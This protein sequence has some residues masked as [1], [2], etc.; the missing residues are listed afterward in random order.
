VRKLVLTVLTMILTI[1]TVLAVVC[2]LYYITRERKYAGLPRI[3]KPGIIG[4][5]SSASRFVLHADE[6]LEE[7]WKQFSGRPFVVPTLGG[8][9]VVLGSEHLEILR[10]SNDTIFNQPQS[11]E[12][13]LQ[14]KYTMNKDQLENPYHL[15]VVRGD[16]TRAIAGFIPDVVDETALAM[17]ETFKPPARSDSI[18]LPLFNTLTH[19]IGRITN[20]AMTGTELCRNEAY[21][22]SV[23]TF[24]ETLIGYA[25]LLLWLPDFIRPPT[26]W[27]ISTLFGGKK[28]PSAFIKPYLQKCVKEREETGVGRNT[29]AEF[30]LQNAPPTE[31]LDDIAVRVL[32]LNFGAIHTSS[33][34]TSQAIF[35]LC[36]LPASDIDSIRAEVEESLQLAGGWNKVALAGFRKLDS[37]LREVGRFYGLG[38]TGMARITIAEGQFPD[39]TI[40]PKGLQCVINLESV[41]F[42][43]EIYPN[44]HIFDPFRF[45]KLRSEEESDVRHGFT[46]V[47][48]NFIPFGTGRHA[49]PGRFFAA[50]ELKII[51]AQ[52]LLKYDFSLP[53]N[54]SRPKNI[55]LNG[56]VFPDPKA[57]IVFRHRHTEKAV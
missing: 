15:P 53:P 29:V 43:P 2:S 4:Y 56:G 42:D 5:I 13:S 50:M 57:E 55:I 16:L 14:L 52:L 19:M 22:N 30:L 10:A 45:S 18:S 26:Y 39:G 23:V 27:V 28:E 38:K 20:R 25:Q 54:T 9:V 24:A 40:I 48:K 49:C 7:G 17:E 51:L 12:H 35:E 11:I 47:D 21:I 8:P 34:F 46:T 31:S 44:P 3:G 32:N 37:L 33:I 36:I 1:I 6:C 41:H